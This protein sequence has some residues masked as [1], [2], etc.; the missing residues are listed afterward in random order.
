MSGFPYGAIGLFV[1]ALLLYAAY[2]ALL[3]DSRSGDAAG[4]GMAMGLAA[5][6]GL[7]LWIAIAGLFALAWFNGRLPAW[8]AVAAIAV[9]PLSGV[10]VAVAAG[11]SDDRGRW[12][13]AA[14]FLLPPVLALY[15]LWGRLPGL[16][17]VLPVAPTSAVLGGMAVLLT[18][19]PLAL[20]VLEVLPNAARDAAEAERQR[21]LEEDERQR[22]EE[23][24][25]EEEAW[26]SQLGPTSSLRDY[27]PYLPPGNARSRQ[28][29]AGA[30]LVLSRNADAVALLKEGRLP[31]LADLWQLDLDPAAVCDAFSS[32]LRTEAVKIDRTRSNHLSIAMDLERQL[33]NISWLA[34]ARCDLDEA[35]ADLE[36][37]LRAVSDSPRFDA[38]ADTL[39]SI[40][41]GP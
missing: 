26:F 10:A 27:L 28:T 25:R 2:A 5:I 29:L 13:M 40:R 7:M 1:V 19:V 22:L 20:G 24:R 41:R 17:D 15:A 21:L 32:A 16:H 35:L 18:A 12:L 33:P 14:P 9:V 6:V 39:A 38:F 37:R 34:G 3:L 23:L 36:R 31:S 11:L 4:R 8:A 30:R